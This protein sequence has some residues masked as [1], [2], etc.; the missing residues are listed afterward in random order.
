MTHYSLQQQDVHWLL[1]DN[2]QLD[3]RSDGEADDGY[4]SFYLCFC[5]GFLRSMMISILTTP[6][7]LNSSTWAKCYRHSS[8]MKSSM[9]F[10]LFGISQLINY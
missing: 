9:F 8:P 1:P 6:V 3:S 7:D 10:F 4:V 2:M 5:F